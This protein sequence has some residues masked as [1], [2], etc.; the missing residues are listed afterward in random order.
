MIVRPITSMFISIES[1]CKTLSFRKCHC[2]KSNKDI[3]IRLFNYAQYFKELKT[4]T[5]NYDLP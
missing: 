2:P 5:I 4:T 3:I 1:T